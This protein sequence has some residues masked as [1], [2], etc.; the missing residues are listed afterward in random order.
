MKTFKT[1][2]QQ[3][4]LLKSRKLI[5]KNYEYAEQE[6]L[7]KNYYNLFN[8]YKEPFLT[9]NSFEGVNLEEIV[10]LYTFDQRL[11]A[12]LLKE[13][14]KIEEHIKALTA[15][16][17]S[18]IHKGD[19]LAYLKKENFLVSKKNEKFYKKLS[20]KIEF[21]INPQSTQEDHIRHY[22]K[23]YNEVPFWVLSKSFS[24]GTLSTF[25]KL[26]EQRLQQKI[27]FALGVWEDE[28]I[29][30]LAFLTLFRNESAHNKRIYSL[31]YRYQKIPTKEYKNI[32]RF[33]KLNAND[34]FAVLLILKRLM[35]EECFQN[36]LTDFKKIIQN[37]Q[38]T[39]NKKAYL[40]I[41]EEMG[42]PDNWE[43]IGNL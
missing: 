1:I 30:Y 7:S 20:S 31:K 22:L 9:G 16:Y 26:S 28:L 17:F 10:S 18:E 33:K 34:F 40:S 4:E 13:I 43:D 38:I 3:I 14:L 8:S 24:I 11:R 29:T 39:I 21:I 19:N 37:L 42:L 23:K 2:E 25:I 36:F 27:G 15:Y 35:R 12:L 5:I 6:L 32:S 41:L